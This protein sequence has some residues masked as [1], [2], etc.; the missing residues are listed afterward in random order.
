MKHL[1]WTPCDGPAATL[2]LCFRGLS[3]RREIAGLVRGNPLLGPC[4]S[5]CILCCGQLLPDGSQVDP[6]VF[7]TFGQVYCPTLFKLGPLISQFKVSCLMRMNQA[8]QPP[9]KIKVTTTILLAR[10]Q[11]RARCNSSPVVSSSR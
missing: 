6:S 1:N 10:P 4:C 8:A 11:Y 9:I 3:Y 2:L 5:Q 7:K